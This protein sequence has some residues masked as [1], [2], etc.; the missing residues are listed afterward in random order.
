MLKIEGNHLEAAD[1]TFNALVA[2]AATGAVFRL[3][4]VVAGEHAEDDGHLL[5]KVELHDALGGGLRDELEMSGL[6]LD[7]ASDADDAIY[8]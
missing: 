1:R 3:L 6:S 4:H 5:L 7:D 8:R 2:V